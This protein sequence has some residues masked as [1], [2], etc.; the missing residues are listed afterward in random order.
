VLVSLGL[1][2][3]SADLH[4]DP[5]DLHNVLACLHHDQNRSAGS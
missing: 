5:A 1:T 3:F 4:R 2:N